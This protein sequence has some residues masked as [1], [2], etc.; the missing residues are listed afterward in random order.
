VRAGREPLTQSGNSEGATKSV[1]L[2]TLALE[3]LDSSSI[4]VQPG[5]SKAEL[6]QLFP[7][8]LRAQ[9]KTLLVATKDRIGKLRNLTYVNRLSLFVAGDDQS[10]HHTS[11]DAG[12]EFYFLRI[13][14]RPKHIQN[15]G[16]Q[17]RRVNDASPQIFPR[18]EP[19]KSS[20]SNWEDFTFAKLCKRY[21]SN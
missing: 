8:T 18:V 17:I 3:E 1:D 16:L 13:V 11:F 10:F 12:C 15:P 4:G 19:L 6:P 21:M 9:L 14:T 2:V 5:C 20:A 7:D